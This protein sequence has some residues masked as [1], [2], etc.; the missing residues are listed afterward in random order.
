[1]KQFAYRL[2][3]LLLS[4]I[5]GASCYAAQSP[6]ANTQGMIRAQLISDVD[7]LAAQTK[8][9]TVGVRLTPNQPQWHHYW[10][11]AGDS[12]MATAVTLT[13]PP[14]LSASPIMWPTPKRILTGDIVSFAYDEPVVLPLRLTAS[15]PITSDVT[16]KAH[17]EWLAC[18]DSCI[19]ESADLELTIPA[20]SATRSDSQSTDALK[21][22]LASAPKPL[23]SPITLT[24]DGSTTTLS[25]P[26]TALP[27]PF[28]AVD[29]F[30]ITEGMV[31]ND[32]PV[33]FSTTGDQLTVT[34]TSAKEPKQGD[35]EAVLLL[36]NQ[37]ATTA[38]RISTLPQTASSSTKTPAPA[39]TTPETNQGNLLYALVLALLGGMI[40]N[41]MPCVL[42]VLSLKLLSLSHKAHSAPALA[43]K[44]GIAYTLGVLACFSVLGVLLV[45]LQQ[46]GQAIGW[47]FQLQS[48]YFVTALAILML[49]VGLNLLGAFHIPDLLGSWGQR[50][51]HEDNTSGSFFTGALAALTATPCTA[52]FMAPA[53]GF[54]L[55]LPPI[56]AVLVFE[57]I[58]LGMALPYL[59]VSFI[60]ALRR[61][62]PRSGAWMVTF[63]Q[64]L[65]FPMFATVAWLLWVMVRGACS[66]ALAPAMSILV[67]TAFGVWVVNH[68]TRKAIKWS[69]LG[70]VIAAIVYATTQLGHL[71]QLE[72]SNSNKQ[73]FSES[74][75]QDLRDKGTPVFVDATADWCLTCKINE[76]RVLSHD[77]IKQHFAQQGIVTLEADW[78]RKDDHITRYLQGLGRNGVPVYVFYPPK[79]EPVLLPQILTSAEVIRTTCLKGACAE[80]PQP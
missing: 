73:T 69:L 54:A 42:P 2:L 37:E 57:M 17:A 64:F 61:L 29:I 5:W 36:K 51:T 52:P 50:L 3:A 14:Q 68:I 47:G 12:G 75:L 16:L 44:H 77:S 60:P 55:T 63:K 80:T 53:V 33:S 11:N 13:L 35:F 10:Q 38:W 24:R 4:I 27:Q 56:S 1:M 15:Q 39:A 76:F 7:A 28:D 34:L 59:A 26:L 43:R 40:L 70:A 6:E 48:P 62:V 65:A 32:A 31:K 72:A 79:G 49:L 67:L 25:V 21:L 58:G 23:A 19:P 74:A 18:H 66:Y 22:A 41:I 8:T 20:A 71:P 78:T 30:P 46:S 9:F 45:G